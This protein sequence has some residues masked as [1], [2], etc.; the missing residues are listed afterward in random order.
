MTSNFLLNNMLTYRD[1]RVTGW[2]VL[3]ALLSFYAVCS[4]GALSET[5]A[6]SSWL[7]SKGPVWWLAGI[8]RLP[9]RRRL[10]YCGVIRTGVEPSVRSPD[11]SAQRSRISVLIGLTVALLV[12]RLWL[13][14]RLELMFDEAYYACGRSTWHGATSII[15]RWWRFGSVFRRGA[16]AATSSACA[17][18][19]P[20]LLLRAPVWFTCCPG[21]SSQSRRRDFGGLALLLDAAI[22]AGAIIVT[23]D[24][25]L[26]FF[27][28]IALYGVAR[29]YA[30]TTHA[31][32]WLSASRWA[33]PQSKYS[34]VTGAGIPCAM[35]TVPRMRV[36]WRRPEPYLAEILAFAIFLPV[37]V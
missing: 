36:W 17:R 22:A 19:A 3:P 15:R 26:V 5:W 11:T 25:P 35:L 20:W 24:T 32:G 7:Y 28:S 37:V 6:P 31:G 27:W 4:V 18:L 10:E 29:F 8:G 12:V 33:S 34:A 1:Q 13:D 16:S 21:T 9:H 14:A 30:A 2:R 23:P